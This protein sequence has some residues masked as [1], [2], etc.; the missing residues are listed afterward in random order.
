LNHQHRGSR[1]KA[2]AAFVALAALIAAACGSDA[3]GVSPSVEPSP[4]PQSQV[5]GAIATPEMLPV[6]PVNIDYS[7]ADPSFEALPGARA[8]YGAYE[9]AG[10]RIEVPD[11]WNGQV[12][13]YAHGF[14]GNPPAL[15][16]SF[17][18]L[19]DYLIAHGYAWAASS[20]SKNGYE[21]GAGARDTHA[22][23]D[24]FVEKVGTPSRSYI[25]GQSMG[26]HVVSLSLEQYPTAYDG[27]LSECGVVSGHEVLDY[28]L[29]WGTLSGYFAGV[30]LHGLTSDAQ[31][32]GS[33]IS[34]EIA[35][36]LG[37]LEDPTQAGSAFAD[38]IK[39][40]TGG[41]RP[42]FREGYAMNYGFNF[43]ILVNA[44][45][46]AGPSNA[47]AQNVDTR[48]T[49]DDGFGVTSEQLNREVSRVEANDTYRD[50]QRWPEFAPMTGRIERPHLTIHGTGDLFV[51]ISLEQSYRRSVD[52]AGSGDLLVQRAIRR[53]GHCAFSDEERTRA[54]E[55]LVSWVA[56]GEKPPGEDLLGD[57]RDA[58]RAFTQPLEAGDPG[59]LEP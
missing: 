46:T 29:S 4:T 26:G 35:P 43:A 37:T 1:A 19:R 16:V 49:I 40:L 41:D 3:S 14:R 8:L 55:D 47:A 59:G 12:V 7:V 17:P 45:G 13:Y 15:T 34:G 23:R 27:A 6:T 36:R 39:N 24:I 53:A 20:Y 52:A 51:P 54:F 5:A 57:L 10:Y 11:A 2:G 33:T 18:P 31:V 21:P 32:F 44:V 58:G 30:D 9:G 25:Y 48:Y 50:P 42:F 38:V 56:T 28:F 22:L